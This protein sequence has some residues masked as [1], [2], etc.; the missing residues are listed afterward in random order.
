MS[1][2]RFGWHGSDVYIYL[3]S[4]GY[5]CCCAC[6]ARS[7]MGSYKAYSTSEMMRHI[8]YHQSLGDHVPKDAIDQLVRDNEQN[9]RYII[10]RMESDLQEA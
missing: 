4:A 2:A 8:D 6:S 1:Y 7:D 5:L 9:M 10:E 3:D